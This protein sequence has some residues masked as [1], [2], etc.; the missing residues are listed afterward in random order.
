MNGIPPVLSLRPD[1]REAEAFIAM[2]LAHSQVPAMAYRPP[3]SCWA[4]V[5]GARRCACG[6]AGM[7]GSQCVRCGGPVG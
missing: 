4:D 7:P 5:Y 2:M 6:G 3:A 1:T